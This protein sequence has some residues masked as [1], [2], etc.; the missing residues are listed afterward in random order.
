MWQQIILIVTAY[1]RTA[2]LLEEF[3]AAYVNWRASQIIADHDQITGARNELINQI[4]LARAQRNSVALVNLNRSLW[5]V[6]HSGLP[7]TKDKSPKN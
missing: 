7:N 3:F 2:R 6:E 5:I 4:R 1:E